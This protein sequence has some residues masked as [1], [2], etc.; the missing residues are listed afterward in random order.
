MFTAVA[1]LTRTMG[2]IPVRSE[3]PHQIRDGFRVIGDVFTVYNKELHPA[4][5]QNFN[6]TGIHCL[7]KG[8]DYGFAVFSFCFTLF[9]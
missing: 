3:G 8:S 4:A 1:S 7:Y 5:S 9:S 2:T 6:H